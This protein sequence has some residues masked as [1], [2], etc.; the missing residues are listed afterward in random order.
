M[1]L[2]DAVL[3][4]KGKQS[5][6]RATA[7]REV[8]QQISDVEKA[9]GKPITLSGSSAIGWLNY[10]A[11]N[12]VSADQL[13][14]EAGAV[15]DKALSSR[16][17]L[18]NPLSGLQDV[19]FQVGVSQSHDIPGDIRQQ[20]ASLN[21]NQSLRRA[22]QAEFQDRM[23]KA[24]QGGDVWAAE[25][26]RTSAVQPGTSVSFGQRLGSVDEM[27][28]LAKQ[29]LGV[30]KAGT[31]AASLMDL[32]GQQIAEATGVENRLTDLKAKRAAAGDF[33]YY[34]GSE[35]ERLDKQIMA[36]S[37]K[38]SSSSSVQQRGLA[39]SGVSSGWTPAQYSTYGK[40]ASTSGS[41]TW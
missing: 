29:A 20:M 36:L 30:G 9:T 3:A 27:D 10:L 17:S 31:A 19:A 5:N 40:T 33:G 26:L 7:P 15:N 22:L 34:P 14:P 35:R 39:A 32:Q 1:I 12:P 6:I 38:T 18:L 21:S 24:A 4:S 11:Q 25:A 28:S 2:N 23:M 37:S 16:T 41:W 8:Q 13:V